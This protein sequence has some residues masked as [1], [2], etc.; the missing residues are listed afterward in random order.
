MRL[1][2]Y[3]N[4]NIDTH[5]DEMWPKILKECKPFLKKLKHGP[6]D[7][8]RDDNGCLLFRGISSNESLITKRKRRKNREPKDTPFLNHQYLDDIFNKKFGWK[9]RSNGIFCTGNGMQALEYGELFVIFPIG[10]FDI[11]WSE[12]VDDLWGYLSGREIDHLTH[13]PKDTLLN[14]WL[15]DFDERA[16][17]TKNEYLDTK[18]KEWEI[19]RTK[20]TKQLLKYYS[21]KEFDRALLSGNEIMLNCSSFYSMPYYKFANKLQ[22]EWGN[23]KSWG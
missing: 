12:A 15:E 2:T 4:E 23:R 8:L 21:S 14:D 13:K 19:I 3:L 22:Q 7:I 1:K 16:D 18:I 11:L 20:Y 6:Y 17:Q 5:W 10:K 9:A